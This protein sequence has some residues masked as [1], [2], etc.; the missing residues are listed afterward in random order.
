MVRCLFHVKHMACKTNLLRNQC[1]VDVYVRSIINSCVLSSCVLSGC[2]FSS[3]VLNTIL[4]HVK[5]TE[6]SLFVRAP[7]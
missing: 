1:V 5:H 3:C 6:H 2:L 7:L 4:F